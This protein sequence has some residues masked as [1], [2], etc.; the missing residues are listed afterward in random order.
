MIAYLVEGM[1]RLVEDASLLYDSLL[2][3][4]KYQHFLDFKET[5]NE[6]ELEFSGDFKILKLEQVSFTYPFST[7]EVLHQID[8][9]IKAGE[10]IAIV[11]ENG[12]GKSTLVK[13]LLRYYD[14]S[15]GKILLNGT[16]LRKYRCE[17]YRKQLSAAFQDFSCFKLMWSTTFRL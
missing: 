10:K 7:I 17:S 3:V 12:S 5:Q 11:G 4:K 15:Q 16:D 6:G 14:P 9:E 2:W 8:L 13:L 1:A